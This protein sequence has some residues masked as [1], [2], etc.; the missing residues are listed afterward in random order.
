MERKPLIGVIGSGECDEET[1]RLA[2][3]VGRKIAEAGYGL[4]CGGLGGVMEA[5]CRGASEAGGLTVGILPSDS[6]NTANPFV[7]VAVATGMGIARNAIIIRSALAVIAIRGGP[8]TLSE[9]AFCLQL[10]VPIVSLKS[11]TLD[12]KII[13]VQ[14]SEEALKEVINRI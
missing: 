7:G 8:G 5:A 4:V 11:F 2:Y 1:E 10:G 14:T 3:E 12:P 13:Q 9:V 6:P